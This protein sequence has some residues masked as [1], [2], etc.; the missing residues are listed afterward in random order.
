SGATLGILK[1]HE[2]IRK[3]WNTE[4][5]QLILRSSSGAVAFFPFSSLSDIETYTYKVYSSDGTRRQRASIYFGVQVQKQD[6]TYIQVG[7][8]YSTEDKARAELERLK[9]LDGLM[10]S[11]KG[12]PDSTSENTDFVFSPA[13]TVTD[14]NR[15]QRWQWST[16]EG[17][18]NLM[19]FFGLYI[20]LSSMVFGGIQI[21]EADKMALIVIPIVGFFFYFVCKSLIS[22]LGTV[23]VVTVQETTLLIEKTRYNE[24]FDRTTIELSK[25]KS[26]V[27]LEKE[28]CFIETPKDW[29]HPLIRLEIATLSTVDQFCLENHIGAVIAKKTG[30][31]PDSF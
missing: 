3:I 1:P 28:L 7:K 6:G 13:V 24:V 4:K 19:A 22:K 18:T 29:S 9:Q 8:G 26:V 30:Q 10:D 12:H 21:G 20:G 25:I 14:T 31:N 16:D 17:M 5:Q 15:L 23:I 27:I 11:K 2:N